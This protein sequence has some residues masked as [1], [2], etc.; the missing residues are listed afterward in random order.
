MTIVIGKPIRLPKLEQPT[1]EQ[2]RAPCS[3]RAQAPPAARLQRAPRPL[4]R[5]PTAAP[6]LTALACPPAATPLLRQVDQY[7][8]QFIAE[9]QGLFE[10]HKAAAG[11]GASTLTVY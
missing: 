2:V 4:A 5:C 11:H 1:P 8:Q 6:L 10:A 7:L 3:Q 9:L